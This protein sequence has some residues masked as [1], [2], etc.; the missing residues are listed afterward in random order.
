[1]GVGRHLLV[2]KHIEIPFETDV[3]DIISFLITPRQRCLSPFHYI[4]S[5]RKRRKKL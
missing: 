1:M 4:L 5:N 2:V 3:P